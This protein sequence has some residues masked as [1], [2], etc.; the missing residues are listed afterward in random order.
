MLFDEQVTNRTV[1][2][3]SKMKVDKQ[4][5]NILQGHIKVIKPDLLSPDEKCWYWVSWIGG[6]IAMG[7]GNVVGVQRVIQFQS[8]VP[9]PVHF[10]AFRTM[11]VEGEWEFNQIEGNLSSEMIVFMT[12]STLATKPWENWSMSNCQQYS[13]KVIE[14]LVFDERPNLWVSLSL[15]N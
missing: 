14:L 6:M 15:S 12:Y 9:F 13:P 1:L 2:S 7:T 10:I 11:N 5:C 4:H 8:R 3:L